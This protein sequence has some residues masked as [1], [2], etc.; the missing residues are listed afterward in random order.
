MANN[1]GFTLYEFAH[2]R[3]NA[4]EA[5]MY[6]SCY[7]AFGWQKIKQPDLEGADK[8]AL[9]FKRDRKIKNKAQLN[10]LQSSC[11]ASL[12]NIIRLEN[13]QSTKALVVSLSTGILGTAALTGAML[14]FFSGRI[15]LF[16][17]MAILGLA[18]CVAPIILHVK[19]LS[20]MD[21]SL[22]MQIEA[23]YEK[24]YALCKQAE[25]LLY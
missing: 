6:T 15:F 22:K 25:K 23:E 7:E 14:C 8:I 12:S 24:V 17:I 16:I 4:S 11:E 13:S 3:V 5:D 10:S 18:G 1:N 2:K 9:K 20:E 19:I 21:E